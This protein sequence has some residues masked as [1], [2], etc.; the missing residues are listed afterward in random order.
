MA[1][2]NNIPLG[3]VFPSTPVGDVNVLQYIINQYISQ[4]QTASI[5]QVTQV[6]DTDALTPVGTVSVK[7]LVNIIGGDG[8]AVPLVPIQNIP[9]FRLQGGGDAVVILPKV[10][11]IGLA[12]FTSADNT[13]VKSTKK[14]GNPGSRRKFSMSDGMYFGGFLNGT[15]SQFLQ[16]LTTGV[17]LNTPGLFTAKS[18]TTKL[19]STT[20]ID[21]T[22]PKVNIDASSNFNVNAPVQTNS[23]LIQAQSFQTGSDGSFNVTGPN[24]TIT[25]TGGPVQ[26]VSQ[27]G[28][29][30]NGQQISTDGGG[31]GGSVTSVGLADTSA[32][33]IFDVSNSP[34]TSAGILALTLKAQAAQT[35]LMGPANGINAQPVFRFIQPSDVPT[36]NQNTTGNAAT[37][38]FATTAATAAL[39]AEAT[40]L[41]GGAA[42][43]IAY[44]TGANVTGFVTAPSISNTVLTWNGSVFTWSAAV[45]GTV[46]SVALTMPTQ[47]T[48]TGS[49]ITSSGTFAVSLSAGYYIPSTTDQTNWN[50]A[51]T[52]TLE[53]SGTATGLVASTGRTSLGATTVGGNFFTLANPSAITFPRINADN[54]ISTLTASAMLAAL[55]AGAGT[56]TSVGGSF[57]GGLI[58]VGGSPI[59]NSGTLALTV[60][61]TSGGV[62]YFN[63][64]STWASS[65][66]LTAN[67]I[68]V[69]GGAGVAPSTIT[70]GTGVLTALGVAVGSA[71][72]LVTNGGA[73][74]TPSS[75]NLANC[76]FPTLNQNTS[77]NAATA[78]NLA[79]GAANRI[80]YQTAAGTTSFIAAPT[81]TGSVPTYNGSSIVW[82][83]PGT[84]ALSVGSYAGST[85]ANTQANATVLTSQ[86]NVTNYN[87]ST[88]NTNIALEASSNP[89]AGTFSYVYNTGSIAMTLWGNTS[90]TGPGIDGGTSTQSVSIPQ[91]AS[92]AYVFD[93]SKWDTLLPIITAGTGVSVTYAIGKATIATVQDIATTASPTFVSETLTGHLNLTSTSSAGSSSQCWVGVVSS[94][95]F[96]NTPTGTLGYF[97]VAN[98]AVISYGV[99]QMTIGAGGTAN[100]ATSIY[101]SATNNASNG[102][103]LIFQRGGA[104]NF[105]LG[106]T[107]GA[108]GSGSGFI[109]YDYNANGIQYYSAG[110]KFSCSA[111][112]NGV[113][114]GTL[115]V[116]GTSATVGNGGTGTNTVTFALNSGNGAGYGGVQIVGQ[117]NGTTSWTIGDQSVPLGGTSNTLAFVN[118][119]GGGYNF[120]NSSYAS[121]MQIDNSGNMTVHGAYLTVG[122]GG[123]T[124]TGSG[125]TINGANGTSYPGATVVG[126]R[127]G[128]GSWAIGD[129]SAI[130]G[131]TSLDFLFYNYNAGAGF[132]FYNSAGANV[133]TFGGTGNFACTGTM[134]SKVYT[135][136]TLPTG[137]E[138][139]RAGVTDATA[140]TF[141]STVVG[142]GSNHVPVYFNGTNWV[143]A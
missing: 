142:G 33:P 60:A 31:G 100:A 14:Q 107:Q 37:A 77:G 66:V 141:L 143:I 72:A 130:Y 36:L 12:V 16:F 88:F 108:L 132:R 6:N 99:G 50:T 2:E 18:D 71:G 25:S 139:M 68:M 7:V 90:G 80:A 133:G 38:T 103:S 42:N 15:P 137:S 75:G 34:I 65:A 96:I 49:P 86:F 53:W 94:G 115:A 135:V 24:I 55:G 76:T 81:V 3:N 1:N 23:G 22:A 69:G 117:K 118:A 51:Y 89:A 84:G 32:T 70:T 128:S 21:A 95:T 124:G 29:T 19:Q 57:T 140:T 136:A 93:G 41:A 35:M 121:S 52:Q 73:L 91:Y 116:Q 4:I 9:Y 46:T 105:Y 106:D 56:V 138:G 129:Y 28:A 92:G 122:T 127:N 67:A 54:S 63:S 27:S 30:I 58:S 97:G 85:G 134:Q 78:T 82:S 131:G 8:N 48:V 104:N 110:V 125:I 109:I 5:V 62:P 101:I 44:Q 120:F 64:A 26:L 119:L 45:A 47:F 17:L 113:F 123:T 59:T 87:G 74:G 126:Q 79:G 98:T 10:G 13:V 11:D 39:A 43:R 102:G 40:N 111:T 114:A 112:G 83:A 20:E 61:G